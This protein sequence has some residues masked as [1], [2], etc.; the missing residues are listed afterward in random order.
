[1]ADWHEANGCEHSHCPFDCDKP[2]PQMDGPDLICGR[3]A[4][5]GNMRVLMVPCTPEFCGE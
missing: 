3:C 1:M 2:Q 4:V 5:L